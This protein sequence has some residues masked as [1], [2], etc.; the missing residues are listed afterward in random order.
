[1]DKEQ[2]EAF[3]KEFFHQ[4]DKKSSH[5]VNQIKEQFIISLNN[6][7]LKNTEYDKK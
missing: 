2:I 6:V 7:L 4:I 3:R 5:G 1:M